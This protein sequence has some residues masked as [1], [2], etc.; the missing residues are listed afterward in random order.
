MP[1]PWFCR[2]DNVYHTHPDCPDGRRA[3]QL[4]AWPG[5]N[6]KPHC[7]ECVRLK[8]HRVQPIA[9]PKLAPRFETVV[10]EAH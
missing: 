7:P 8:A 2:L 10:G 1:V 5:T 3:Q 9:E 4:G 6:G